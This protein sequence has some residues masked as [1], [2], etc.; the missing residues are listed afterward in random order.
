[1]AVVLHRHG[2]EVVH[3]HLAREHQALR[4]ECEVGRRRCEPR[5]L[6]PRLEEARADHAAGHLLDAEDEHRVVLSAG[7]LCRGQGKGRGAT[8]AARLDVDDR[9]A[10][11]PEGRQHLVAGGDASVDRAAEGGLEAA[12]LD[13]GVAQRG[14]HRLHAER[15]ET[16]VHEA[17][18]RVQADTGDVDGSHDATAGA[19]AYDMTAAPSSSVNSGSI[20]SVTGSPG[21]RRCRSASVSRVMTWRSTPS[22]ST[23]PNPYGTGP[24]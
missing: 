14:P 13:P 19:K 7:D 17:S 21:R 3:A 4:A 22:S 8:G 23:T 9:H 20:T 10:G 24:R 16:A 12:A 6:A 18:E 5:L 2:G 15:G 1:M 11:Q